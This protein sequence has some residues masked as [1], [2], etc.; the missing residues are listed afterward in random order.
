M[1]SS[2]GHPLG[3]LYLHGS[4]CLWELSHLLAV[5]GGLSPPLAR[6]PTVA[7]TLHTNL[8]PTSSSYPRSTESERPLTK[9]CRYNS[10]VLVLLEGFGHLVEQLNK[11]QEE[12]A[13]LKNLRE[14][15]VEQFRGISEEWIQRENGYKAEIKRL[16]LVL[17]KESKNGVA[18][19][20]L[21][22]HG[23]LINRSGTKRFQARLK[24]LS[25]SQDAGKFSGPP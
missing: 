18:S 12:L 8:L 7:W 22:R 25:S 2:E 21:A 10:H 23:S 19:V 16:E 1:P 13:E 5:L 11:T 6:H 15:E 24:R 17:A 14:K 20:A 4:H 9:S 3:G